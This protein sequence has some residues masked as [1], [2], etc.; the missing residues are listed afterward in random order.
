MS[1]S[2]TSLAVNRANREVAH[3]AFSDRLEGI[4]ADL[5]ARSVGARMA[6]S[7]KEGTSDALDAGLD[8]AKERKGLIAGTLGAL[9]LWLFREPLLTIAAGLVGRIRGEDDDDIED[10]T[11]DQSQ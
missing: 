6:D 10:E 11:R 1:G 8:V 7:V 2:E 9:L 4:K 5:A 3:A